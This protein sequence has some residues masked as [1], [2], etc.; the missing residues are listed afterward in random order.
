MGIPYVTAP[1]E[2]E[3]QCAALCKAGKV[4]ATAT[5]DMDSLTFG[6]PVLLRHLTFSEARK[7]PIK[8][9]HLNQVLSDLGF[10][11]DEF[12]DLCILLGCDYTDSIRG[13]GPKSAIDLMQ[14]HRTIDGILAYLEKEK[15]DKYKVPEDWPFDEARR[16]FKTPDVTDPATLTFKWKAP[17]EEALVEYMCKEKGF[18]EDRIRSGC[19]K[20]KVKVGQASQGRLDSFFKVIPNPNAG[21]KAK[22]KLDK[23]KADAKA[24]AKAGK[25][26]KKGFGGKPRR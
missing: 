7:M 12:I 18:Q 14:K 25:A 10:T 8:E 3:A 4:W 23:Q 22:A 2:A 5:E 16:L 24:K 1:C 15:K 21:A 20:L 11:Q 9:F 19:K 6:S 13:I 17:N 26:G